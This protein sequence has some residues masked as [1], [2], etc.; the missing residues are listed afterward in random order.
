MTPAS[1][2]HAP[3]KGPDRHRSDEHGNM[4][5]AFEHFDLTREIAALQLQKSS[6]SGVASR[7]LFKNADLRVV[8][9]ALNSGAK[10]DEHHADGTIS[11][12][13]LRGAIQLR[14]QGAAHDLPAGHLF[15][16]GASLPHSVSASEDSVFLLT[17]SWPR[18]PEL[19]SLP[20][21]GY[22]T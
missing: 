16:L 21:R 14:T 12:H 15:T 5:A 13:V 4:T 11:V 2:E 10:L 3:E 1:D 20:H 8:L 9:L 17:L 7:L 18:D 6:K 22:G 19:R